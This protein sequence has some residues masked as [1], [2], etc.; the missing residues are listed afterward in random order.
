M[1]PFLYSTNANHS[2]QVLRPFSDTVYDIVLTASV[3]GHCTVPAGATMVILNCT[4][5]VYVKIGTS[6]VT[7]TVPGSNIVDGTGSVI[8]PAGCVLKPTDT[9]ISCISPSGC[10][11]SLEFYA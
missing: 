6:S 4:A 1:T 2:Q 7:A 9:T 3:E 11:V 8:N 5:N 10:V